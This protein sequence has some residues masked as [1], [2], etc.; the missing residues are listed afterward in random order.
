M[1]GFFFQN[2]GN[3]L[4]RSVHSRERTIIPQE[5]RPALY[6]IGLQGT[7]GDILSDPQFIKGHALLLSLVK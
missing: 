3:V 7:V 5:R 6:I 2:D 4:D 1:K